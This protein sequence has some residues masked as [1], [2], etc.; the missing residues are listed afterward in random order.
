MAD[1]SSIFP[2]ANDLR[3]NARAFLIV[4][5]EVRSIENALL[6]A[7][8][9]GL[10]DAVVYNTYM[11]DTNLEAFKTVTAIN[12]TTNTLTIPNHGYLTGDEIQAASTGILPTPLNNIDEY[13]V[14][15]V[16]A[17]NIK[18]AAGYMDSVNNAPIDLL[19]AG[20]GTHSIRKFTPAQLYYRTWQGLRKDRAQIDHMNGVIKHFQDL[21]YQIRRRTNPV[22][23][24][25]FEWVLAW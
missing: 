19:N 15:V 3:S 14:I 5:N 13:F 7:A 11:T 10:V 9:N 21:Q 18:L 24:N 25:T 22:T 1:L 2:G 6:L 20:T 17:N 8:D 23:G 12:I 16:D 4:H